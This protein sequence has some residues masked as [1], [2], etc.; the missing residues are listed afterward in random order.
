MNN[1]IQD[2]HGV[3]TWVIHFHIDDLMPTFHGHQCSYLSLQDNNFSNQDIFG[4]Y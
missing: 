3:N 4:K 1:H 2:G